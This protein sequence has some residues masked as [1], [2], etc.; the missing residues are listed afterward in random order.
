MGQKNT[1][2]IE[3]AIYFKGDW[4]LPFKKSNTRDD[5]FFET[6]EKQFP[7]SMMH[8]TDDFD[9][10]ET[11]EYQVLKLPYAGKKLSMLITSV[12]QIVSF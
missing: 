3:N 8:L 6:A 7:V 5:P 1:F 4:N 11:K 9:Y 10:M 12:L 2:F